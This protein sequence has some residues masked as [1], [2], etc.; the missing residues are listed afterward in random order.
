MN[1]ARPHIKGIKQAKGVQKRVADEVIWA[2]EEKSKR[3]PKEF[4][5]GQLYDFDFPS[6]IITAIISSKIRWVGHVA[7]I[8]RHR[9]I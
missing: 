1:L 9:K 8:G 3:W 6:N 7:R 4:H 5:S 2:K